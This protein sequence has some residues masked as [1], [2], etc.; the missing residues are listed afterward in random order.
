MKHLLPSAFNG[1]RIATA[2]ALGAL[3]ALSM[4]HSA[5]AFGKKFLADAFQTYDA[6]TMDSAGAFLIGELERLDPMLHEPLVAVSWY[7]DID[8]RTDVAMADTSS[9]YILTAFAAGGGA[10]PGG[11]NWASPNNTAIPRFQLDGKKIVSPLDLWNGEVSY[12]I[13]EMISAQ[14]LGR[15]IDTQMMT[16]LNLK[17]QMDTDQLVYIGDSSKGTTGL[18]NSSFVVNT[19]NVV[20]GAGGSPLWNLKTPAEILK[21][22]NDLIVSVWAA[23]GWA[24]APSKLLLPPVQFGYIAT[25]TISSAGTDSILKYIREN[26]VLTAQFKIPLDIQPVKWAVGSYRGA[27]SDRMCAYVQRPDYIRFPKVPMVPTVQQYAG[28][29]IKVP[30]YGRL[31]VL[32]VVYPETIGY[33]DGI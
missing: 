27:G 28:I 5:N 22:V 9:S 15:P 3:S 17:D 32:E 19:G 13:P 23:S 30:Y 20:N 8:L 26:N 7:R 31:G 10:A 11:I 1:A 6:A 21:D 12:T 14:A 33:R 24:V 29:W 16:A 18:L 4:P 2:A 25:Q